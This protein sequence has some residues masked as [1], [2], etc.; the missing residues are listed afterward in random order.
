MC[1]IV[2]SSS[3]L[4]KSPLVG[5]TL[6]VQLLLTYSEDILC[7]FI[8]SGGGEILQTLSAV[9]ISRIDY[10]NRRFLQGYLSWWSSCGLVEGGCSDI[11]RL[12]QTEFITSCLLYI[13]ILGVLVSIY[14]NLLPLKSTD[15]K[16]FHTVFSSDRLIDLY[17][18]LN[19]N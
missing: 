18:S 14:F 15:Q 10:F 13:Q 7:F 6:L 11:L 8:S 4:R 3:I 16:I 2:T 19:I 12:L 17:R 9:L 5:E 1:K